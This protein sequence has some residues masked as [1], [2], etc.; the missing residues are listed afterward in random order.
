MSGIFFP[1]MHPSLVPAQCPAWVR[2]LSPGMPPASDRH[3]W[4][5]P[6]SLPMSEAECKRYAR[7]VTDFASQF[8]KPKE[9]AELV[10]PGTGQIPFYDQT[11]LAIRDDLN[12]R[13]RQDTD[14]QSPGR[15][16]TYRLQGQMNLIMAWIIE[17]QAVEL[18]GLNQRWESFQEAM[19]EVL[20]VEDRPDD[21]WTS[22]DM[23][24]A[25]TQL[26]PWTRL[27]PWFLLFIGPQ[28]ALV[29][30]EIEIIDQWKDNGLFLEPTRPADH[31]HQLVEAG[32]DESRVLT[33][34][35]PGAR[36]LGASG[37]EGDLPW[38]DQPVRVFCLTREEEA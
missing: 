10:G 4:F 3:L 18:Q 15:S 27:L 38:M 28:D 33:A 25:P 23:A 32:A 20:G 37:P 16:S 9:L 30:Q 22:A 13:L 36:L 24:H 11:G 21:P 7:Q 8:R 12:A 5:R 26:V 35:C 34:V 2:F 14:P 19:D 6:Q 17:E 1:R 29:V 31:P